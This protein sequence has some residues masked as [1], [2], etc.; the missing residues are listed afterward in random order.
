MNPDSGEVYRVPAGEAVPADHIKLTEAEALVLEMYA[1]STRPQ[2]L[3]LWR[4]GKL[5]LLRGYEEQGLLYADTLRPVPIAATHQ[6]AGP[7]ARA[8]AQR[9]RVAMPKR[10]R[11]CMPK[12]LRR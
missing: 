4:Q 2:L 6:L 7:K 10:P 5:L 11:S 8:K 12:S 9:G 1:P 3:R